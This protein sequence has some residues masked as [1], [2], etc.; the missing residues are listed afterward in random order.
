MSISAPETK[1]LFPLLVR[2]KRRARFVSDCFLRFYTLS[3]II[4]SVIDAGF[5]TKEFNEHPNF[6]NKKLP[7][8]FTIFAT[9]W[10]GAIKQSSESVKI[11]ITTENK[12][13]YSEL[14]IINIIQLEV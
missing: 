13:G 14:W 10:F 8:E 4:N 12:P 9:D 2:I 5:I 7:V 11:F 3:E 1:N 6:V